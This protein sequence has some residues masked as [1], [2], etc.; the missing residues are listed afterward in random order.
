[1]ATKNSARLKCQMC[2][3]ALNV[4]EAHD[5]GEH[6]GREH[7]LRQ[8]AQQSRRKEHDDQREERGDQARE[9]RARAGA[10]VDER[11]RHAAAHREPATESREQIAGAKRQQLLVGVEPIAVLLAEHAAD[12]GRLDGGEDEARQ[13]DRQQ[14]VQVVPADVRQPEGRQAL[15][16]LSQQRHALRLE[17][18]ESS[19]DNAGDDNEKGDRPV[20]QPELAGDERRQRDDADEQRRPVRVAEMRDEVRASAPRS[21]RAS[22]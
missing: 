18:Q 21:R 5:G 19:R 7:R 6:D 2:R 16:H 8:V 22:L 17:I 3:S 9:R 4:D 13:R 1:M 20:L 10:L 15:R 11:L 12:G 14:L